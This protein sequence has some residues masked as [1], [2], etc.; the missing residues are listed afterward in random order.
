MKLP[1][2][3]KKD[4]PILA[5]DWNMLLDALAA[6]TPCTGAGLA[7]ASSSGGFA[8]SLP[9]PLGQLPKGQ[10]PFSVI[11]IETGGV[12]YL[13]T[14]KEGWVIERQPMSESSPAVL[15]HMPKY[16]TTSLN[17]IPRP[18]L[19]MAIND[20]AW[21]RYQTDETGLI[22]AVPEIVVAAADQPGA[23]YYP[24]DPEASGQDGDF[25]VK[26]FKL[27]MDG[28]TP[29]IIV[30]Q[31]SDIEHYAQLW[32]G[33]N[34]GTGAGVFKQ[35]DETQNIYQFRTIA[36]D[37]GVTVTED[38]DEILIE[39][40]GGGTGGPD[41][42]LRILGVKLGLYSGD[43]SILD[44]S[45]EATLYVRNGK[46]AAADATDVDNYHI[47]GRVYSD[48]NSSPDVFEDNTP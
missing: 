44:S 37:N 26:L 20:I 2:R 11:A 9:T 15:F 19:S 17:T 41:F 35:H 21:C 45:V 34:T 25:Y 32:T 4:D 6:R 30:Y 36:G 33:E 3:K 7:L 22:S 46:F 42:N 31:Q 1:P 48:L 47:I 16:G 13:V 43:V 14:I 23:H 5:S 27:V 8:Y 39:L 29:A 38:G 10:S 28:T 18:Q 24:V 12:S 40:E